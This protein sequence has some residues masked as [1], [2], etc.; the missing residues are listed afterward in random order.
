MNPTEFTLTGEEQAF[1]SHFN[2]ETFNHRLGPAISWLNSRGLHWN[3]MAGFQQ[4]M[5]AHDSSFMDKINHEELL[6]PFVV[7]W[8]SQEEFLS[9]VESSLMASPDL[10][11]LLRPYLKVEVSA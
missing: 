8:D 7:P 10:R 2:A 6:P 9:R 1:L 11:P 4:W 5:A 3:L